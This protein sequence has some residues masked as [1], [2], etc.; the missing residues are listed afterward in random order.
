MSIT[1]LIALGAA[2]VVAGASGAQLVSKAAVP[3]AS[4][5]VYKSPT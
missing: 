3:T 2:L 1:K 5:T 4:I